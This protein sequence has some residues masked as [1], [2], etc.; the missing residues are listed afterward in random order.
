[1]LLQHAVHLRLR[2]LAERRVGQADVG[3][4]ACARQ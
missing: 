3:R 2:L 1:L 4:A